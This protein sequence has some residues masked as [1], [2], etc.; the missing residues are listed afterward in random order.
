[1][2]SILK[3]FGQ[4]IQKDK[5]MELQPRLLLH[6]VMQNFTKAVIFGVNVLR[7]PLH[8]SQLPVTLSLIID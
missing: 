5:K 1:M 3:T 2:I 8:K 4:T 6:L 7:L